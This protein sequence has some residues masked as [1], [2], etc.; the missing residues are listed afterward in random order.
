MKERQLGNTA[1][2]LLFQMVSSSDHIS[3]AT[4]LSL[5]VTISKNGGSFASPSGAVT[6]IANGWYQVAG[7]ATDANTLGPLCLHATGAGADPTDSLFTVVAYNPFDAVRMGLTALP[8]A[9]A[10]ASG[11]VP[12]LG[13]NATAISF[14]GG[15]VISNAVG[16]ALA[17]SS[18]GS[19][20]SGLNASGNGTGAGIKGTGGAT[21]RGIHGI[22]GAT[23]GAGIRGEGA[24]GNSHGIHGAGIG[25][26]SGLQL[27]A[28]TTGSGMT[29]LGGATSGTG[30]SITTTSGDGISI[31]PTVGH[32]IICTANGTSKHG[33]FVT[34][35]TAG[36]SDGVKAVA[37]TGGVDIRGNITGSL[38]GSV[39]SVATG[40]IV[41]ASFASGA[42]DATALAQGAA[43][44]VWATT[45]RI[46]TA[47]TN[48]A[49]AK[50]TGIT[51][52]N[53]IAATDVWAATT[54]TLSAGTN[55]ALAKGTGVTGFNDITA[56]SV[57]GV[58]RSGNQTSGSFGEYV[59]AAISTRS[60]YAGGAVASVTAAVTVGT[61]NDK[62]GYALSSSGLDLI[63]TT[64]P[65]GVALTF[66]AMLVQVWRRFFKKSTLTSTQLQ[67]YADDGSTVVTTQTVSDD[68][69]TQ[70]QGAAS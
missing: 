54:R 28:G 55:I 19:N 69:T 11:G 40:G 35:G 66:P 38:S 64:A 36:T 62:T 4:G 63:A 70:T 48:I 61:N 56:A 9:N 37:G 10:A 57:W 17:L 39:G 33:V 12:V 1:Y 15:M 26:G 53:D 23:S 45:T 8:N 6:E 3:A 21:G 13:T 20:G 52:L 67:T 34:G 22:G 59:D 51:G 25:T 31:L 30:I 49:L 46:L 47:G 65:S 2:P 60:T 68:G 7:N 29:I 58:A 14:T 44:K 50:G 42:I 24:G 16:D 5:T 41:A 18:S 32:G 27:D 43:D